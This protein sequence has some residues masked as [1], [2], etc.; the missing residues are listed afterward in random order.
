MVELTSANGIQTP[1]SDT[2]GRTTTE[3]DKDECESRP[4]NKEH[5][6]IYK[7]IRILG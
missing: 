1:N 7:N 4:S 2:T 5:R 3:S 6:N